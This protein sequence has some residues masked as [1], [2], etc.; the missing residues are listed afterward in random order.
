MLRPLK[1][2]VQRVAP[3]AGPVALDQPIALVWIDSA[4]P[5]LTEAF[6]YLIPE[7][8]SASVQVGSRVQVPFKEKHL[9]ALVIARTALGANNRDLKSIY[10]VVGE[11]PVASP[12]TLELIAQTAEFWGGTP[13]DVI[14]SA[15]PSRVANV[16]KN[17]RNR[18]I[19]PK[20]TSN[21]SITFNLLPPKQE[22]ISALI[23]LVRSNKSIGSRLVIVPTARELARLADEL[24]KLKIGFR[25]IDSD[26]PRSE[27][28]RNYLEISL[29]AV[30]LVIGMRTAIFSPIPNLTDI[31][32][33][34]ENSE[35]YYER[36]A[37]Y[38]NARDVS[39]LRAKLGTFNLHLTGYIPSLE[40]AISIDKKQI[41]YHATRHKNSVVA[42]TG[43]SGELIPSKIYQIVRKSLSHGPV[44]FLVPSKGYATAISCAKCRNMALCNCGGKLTKSSAKSDPI[45]VLCG[46]IYQNWRC[47]WCNESRIFLVSR[48]IER[49]A[50]E[51]GR[52]FPNQLLIQSTGNDSKAE[53]ASDPAIIVATP[54]VEPIVDSGYSA[55][56][57]LQTDRFLNSTS[58]N[59]V[60]RAYASFFSASA[61]I[62]ESGV[63]AIVHEEAAPIVS[64]LTTW[65]PAIIS[66]REIEQRVKLQ[67]PPV[68]SAVLLYA[69]SAELL[70]IKRAL[71]IARDEA[72]AP[73]SLRIY[74]PTPDS[75]D[76]EKLT[77]LVNPDSQL[78]VV[79]LLREINKRRA[80]SKKPL[81]S[82]RINPLA[83]N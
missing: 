17:L 21:R 76:R 40:V 42:Q 79:K 33:H 35:H 77:L 8:L 48:G 82:Y 36:R 53:V 24:T 27:R 31:F 64:A 81:I 54:G 30:D 39:L 10:K 49:F 58:S 68:S 41:A 32:L 75:S 38:W 83:L 15:I 69:E 4:I 65:N 3:P 50:E 46:K 26:L 52:S 34:Q 47:G 66:K 60:E 59:G 73:K 29:G 25:S 13:Y 19:Q 7:K 57:I 67:L 55:V 37:P 44:L 43:N 80:I 20:V 1:L 11:F 28:Y 72:R 51:I 74:G 16:E 61:L 70:R 6:S 22:P 71:E 62:Q 63:I 12:E 5:T 18:Q 56:V 9:E 14:R 23:D 45:C 2:K 78:E